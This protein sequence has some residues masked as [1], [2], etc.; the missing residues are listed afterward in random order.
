MVI[1]RLSSSTLMLI[2][3][4]LLHLISPISGNYMELETQCLS[5]DKD[6]DGI[7]SS[8]KQIYI[9]MPAKAAGSSL[10]VFTAKCMHHPP[11]IAEN[12][13]LAGFNKAYRPFY[14][15]RL[16]TS[17]MGINMGMIDLL[18]RGDKDIVIIYV[19]RNEFER[20]LSAIT[21]TIEKR[22]CM[23]DLPPHIPVQRLENNICV[24]KEDYL[25]NE[26]ILSSN[27]EQNYDIVWGSTRLLTCSVYNSIEEH[28]P[29]VLFMNYKQASTLQKIISKHLCPD[30]EHGVVE[31]TRDMADYNAFVELNNN[32]RISIDDWYE[33]KH[34]FLIDWVHNTKRGSCQN[35][36]NSLEKSLFACEDEIIRPYY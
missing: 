19:H 11:N 12:L 18:N 8:A 21:H 29:N 2:L 35:E 36:T 34:G 33:R 16:V 27:L 14:E 13:L 4:L 3:A 25:L 28:N 9:L 17:H 5:F 24:I 32:T 23:W 20:V 22:S 26:V 1:L 30:V 15:Q 7:I 31:N 10:K 6:V